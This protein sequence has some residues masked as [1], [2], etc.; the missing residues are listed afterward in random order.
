MR[1][2]RVSFTPAFERSYLKLP[3]ETRRMIAAAVDAFIGRSRENA[4]RPELKSGLKGIWTFRVDLGL[5]VFYTQERDAEGRIS[6]LFHVGRHDDYRT[7]MRG[8]R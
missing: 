4:L 2:R 3:P 7:I 6:E 1:P 8:R 5:R